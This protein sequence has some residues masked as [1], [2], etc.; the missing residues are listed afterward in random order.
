M[1]TP[2]FYEGLKNFGWP[3]IL[4]CMVAW[5]LLKKV[6]P[7]VISRLENSEKFIQEVLVQRLEASEKNF[8]S[9]LEHHQQRWERSMGEVTAQMKGVTEALQQDHRVLETIVREVQRK[10]PRGRK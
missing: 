10:E 2:E 9:M 6:W 8:G 3:I 5:F 1:L 7:F 4:L